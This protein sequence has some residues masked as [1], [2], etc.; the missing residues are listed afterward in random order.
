MTPR[1]LSLGCALALLSCS[2]APAPLPDVLPEIAGAW[3]RASMRDVAVAAPPDA[4]PA[5]AIERIRTARYEGA[6]TLEARVY[7]LVSPAAALDVVREWKAAPDTVF[8]YSGRFFVVVQWQAAERKALREFVGV[9]E[10]RL[11]RA[12]RQDNGQ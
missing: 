8:F 4:V 9:L 6:G 1:L 11:P 7:Q 12:S 3:H 2:R 5:A 10:K